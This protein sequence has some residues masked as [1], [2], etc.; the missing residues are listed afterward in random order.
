[1]KE[2]AKSQREHRAGSRARGLRALYSETAAHDNL[3]LALTSFVG[4]EAELENVRRM[5]SRGRLLTLTGAG[6]CG[7]TRLALEA[8]RGIAGEICDGPADGH[9]GEFPDGVWLVELASL[10]EPS[11]VAR[12]AASVLGVEERPGRELERELSRALCGE[13]RLI[14]L[15]NCEHLV[16]ACAELAERLLGRCPGLGM[17]A[18]SREP[19]GVAGERVWPVPALSVPDSP[20]L[21]AA[22]SCDSARLFAERAAATS[23]GFEL[24]EM[25]APAVAEVCQRLEG[26]PLAIELAASRVSTVT[27]AQIS[28]RLDDALGVLTSGP[29]TAPERQRTLRATL[30]WSH[31]LLSRPERVFFRSLSV[32]SGGFTLEAAEEVCRVEAGDEDR[33][34][35]LEL[36]SRL[37]DKSLVRARRTGETA[38]YW[39]PEVIR[40]YASRKLEE[41]GETR[42]MRLRHALFFR[43][44][45]EEAEPGLDGPDREFWLDLV[46]EDLDNVRAAL[47]WA[48]ETGETELG[49]RLSSALAW[50]WLRRGHLAEGRAVLERALQTGAGPALVVARAI[51]VYGGIAWTQGDQETAGSLLGESVARFR[52]LKDDT[53]QS[54]THCDAWLSSAL[55]AY[56]FE[57]LSR[58]ETEEALAAATE[59]VAVGREI[60]DARG[61]GESPVAA[62]ALAALGIARMAAGDFEGARPTLQESAD[63]CRRLG[64]GWLL[65]VPLGSLAVLALGAGDHEKARSLVEESV[66]ALRDLSDEWLLS[67]SLSYLAVTLVA[68]SRVRK[69]AT[70]FGASEAMREAVGQQE[71]YAHYRAD[72][73]WGVE[74]ARNALG[75]EGF[76]AAWSG[77]RAMGVEEAISY[78]LEE[79][80]SPEESTLPSLRILALGQPRVEVGGAPVTASDWRYTKVAE[81]FFYLISHP[82][83]TREKVGLDLWPEAS[84]SSLRNALHSAMYRLRKALG[85]PDRITFSG[86]RYSFDRTAD[87][88]FDAADFEDKTRRARHCAEDDTETATA[89]LEEA[90]GLYRGDFLEG[91]AGGEWIF[92]RQQELRESY[93]QSQLFLGRLHSQQD[94]HTEAAEAYRRAVTRDPYSAEAHAG[95]IRA[96]ARLGERGRA[97]QHYRNLEDT[98][99]KDLGATP[100]LEVATLIERLRGG[101]EV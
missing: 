16:E 37:V 58:G 97:L 40:Q 50:F 44:F 71:V 29:R 18:T 38:H 31:D 90:A 73:N 22:L 14:L 101:E 67:N 36:L 51:H 1:M 84:P 83:S 12:E 77:G 82:P 8:A 91:F 95:I 55:S 15:D 89:L 47:S 74:S 39:L 86:G 21:E 65:S 61:I 78:A 20:S 25:N 17:L 48:A 43:D 59:S 93:V 4:R 30:D 19:L 88:S 33:E 11:L 5:A 9:G 53:S 100:P 6:G 81:L 32:F 92:T 66:R 41:A 62:R 96:Y 75:E 10:R 35:A 45:A 27:A 87:H 76:A 23:P 26:T 63:L 49:L 70:L 52:E 72:Y 56:S 57:R 7:K 54:H 99:H 60:W 64:D 98:F 3:P 85:S 42:A 79:D 28:A 94:R 34:P 69:A 2:D 46:Y 24:T 80:E 68:R 13:R